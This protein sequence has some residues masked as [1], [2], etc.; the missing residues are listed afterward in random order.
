MGGARGG[1]EHGRACGFADQL[2]EPMSWR[3][4]LLRGASLLAAASTV[5]TRRG[6]VVEFL[7]HSSLPITSNRGRVY[8]A[9]LTCIMLKPDDAL[10]QLE[11]LF[12]LLFYQNA[13][14][15][16]YLFNCREHDSVP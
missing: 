15:S 12:M 7:D 10:D 9:S 11:T 3:A 5:V 6:G 1:R 14:L 13:L 4:W 16:C 8:D 2:V